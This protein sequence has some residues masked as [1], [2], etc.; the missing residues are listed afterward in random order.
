MPSQRNN[1][2]NSTSRLRIIK[3]IALKALYVPYILVENRLTPLLSS[4][5]WLLIHHLWRRLI[6]LDQTSLFGF[7]VLL[8][9]SATRTKTR[10]EAISTGVAIDAVLGAHVTPI[11]ALQN[12]RG[13]E[14]GKDAVAD[15]LGE[16]LAA[17]VE[18]GACLYLRSRCSKLG[19]GVSGDLEF[20]RTECRDTTR[21][22]NL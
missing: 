10:S 18:T 15:A 21:T 17:R 3:T 1:L 9:Q 14:E 8:L 19:I 12:R 5:N 7:R 4:V 13:V 20:R 2:S 11:D 16:K 22:Y 6:L